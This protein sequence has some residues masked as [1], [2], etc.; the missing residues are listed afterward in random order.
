MKKATFAALKCSLLQKG[1][2][3]KLCAFFETPG[4][5]ETAGK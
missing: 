5:F 3:V 4:R 2:A 1:K